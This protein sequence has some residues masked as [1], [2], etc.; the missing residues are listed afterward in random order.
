MAVSRQMLRRLGGATLLAAFAAAVVGLPMAVGLRAPSE[1][2]FVASP[3]ARPRDAVVIGAPAQLA[4]RMGLSIEAGVLSGIDPAHLEAGSPIPRLKADS[5]RFKLDLSFANAV[6]IEGPAPADALGKVLV[7]LA[8]LNVEMLSIRRSTLDLARADG[9]LI[10]LTEVNADISATRRD[11]YAA[12]GTARFA[13]HLIDFEASWSRPP[14]AQVASSFPLKFQVSGNF[15]AA[16]F[17]GRVDLAS[18]LKLEG[19]SEVRA[20]KLRALARW[21]GLPVEAG[22]DLRDASII[23][24]M[25]WASGRLSFPKAQV[26]VDGNTGSGVLSLLTGGERPRIDGTL[27]FRSFALAPYYTTLMMPRQRDPGATGEAPAK[28][29]LALFD[30]D[31]RLSAAKLMAPGFELGRGALTLQLKGGR[32]LADL[33]EVEVEGGSAGG[34]ITLDVSGEEPRLGLKLR[35]A[36]IDPGRLFADQLKRNPL[37]GRANV[38]LDAAGGG[39]SVAD[40][41]QALNGRGTFRLV[42][43]GRLGIDL[44]A[45]AYILQQ[46]EATG[47]QTAGKGT[48]PLDSLDVRFQFARGGLYF[49]SIKAQ[50][51]SITYFG[52]GQADVLNHLLDVSVAFGTGPA[53]EVPLNARDVMRF[54]GSWGNPNMGLV[55]SPTTSTVPAVKGSVMK[56]TMLGGAE[57]AT[58]TPMR[59]GDLP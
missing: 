45:L 27:A 38:T 4:P 31:L 8:E 36:E 35:A 30:A 3:M 49:D 25:T 11:G 10:R 16:S 40:I 57:A 23:G 5:A 53:S 32:M 21:L 42:E 48:T 24:D 59:A 54:W 56:G 26:V 29:I 46:S 14:G 13:G 12:K 50:A 52:V 58:T 33:A 9:S 6:H 43:S 7:R 22:T 39:T 44:K 15:I 1:G 17:E 47:W 41:L 28:S 20:R 51:G 37:L 55:Q 19:R 34:Q 18:G 2:G